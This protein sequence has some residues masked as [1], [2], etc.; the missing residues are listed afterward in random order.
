MQHVWHQCLRKQIKQLNL[1]LHNVKPKPLT[2]LQFIFTSRYVYAFKIDTI[3]QM[4]SPQGL[5]KT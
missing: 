4:C 5:R 1:D 2:T 3:Q